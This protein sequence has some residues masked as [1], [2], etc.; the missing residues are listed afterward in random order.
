MSALRLWV[1]RCSTTEICG[2][3]DNSGPVS[4]IQ[5]EVNGDWLC[6]LAATAY[7]EDLERAG[8]GDGRRGFALPLAGR[9]RPG[10]NRVV[11]KYASE[12]V[13]DNPDVLLLSVDHPEAHA[14]SQIRWRGDEAATGLTWGRLMTGDSLWDLYQRMR[15]FA[16]S[17]RILEIGPGYGRLLKTAMARRVPFASYTALELSESRVA[18]L[19]GDFAISGVEFIQGDV[20]TWLGAP[21]FDVVICSST[22]E[23]LHPDCRTALKN[24]RRQL[25]DQG[26]V[27]IDFIYRER[28][29][30]SF[31]DNGTYVR[32]YCRDELSEIFAECGYRVQAIETCALGEDALGRP[33]I[34]F[35]V[36]AD[37]PS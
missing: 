12:I 36:A 20:D 17:D 34:R 28:S 32:I 33:V 27:F 22:F 37:T 7:R 13:Y 24:V 9:L 25:A 3:I 26:Q 21:L 2:W 1:D 14:I 5:I 31:E 35:V 19:R 15:T 6:T 30:A 8:L 23:H 4:P 16:S 10:M 29:S 11:I 18:Q